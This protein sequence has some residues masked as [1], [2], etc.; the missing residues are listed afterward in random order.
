MYLAGCGDN[1]EENKKKIAKQIQN[2][3]AFAKFK[4]LVQNQGGDVRYLD[5][6]SKFPKAKFAE[7]IKAKKSGYIERLDAR[8]IG[9]VSCALGA[10]RVKKEDQIDKTVGIRLLK[11]Q[12]EYVEEGETLAIVYANDKEKIDYESIHE[13]Y[14]IGAKKEKKIILNVI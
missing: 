10:G 13:A 2:G 11:K 1:I 4:Q 12:G 14:K 6:I 7:E 5:D 3:E 8:K 9:E